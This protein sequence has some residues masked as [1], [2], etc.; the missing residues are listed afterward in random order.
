MKL[1]VKD[2]KFSYSSIPILE[3]ITMELTCSEILGIVGP[4]GAGKST[5]IRCIDNIL[6]P[7][8]GSIRLD[9]Q[10]I[11]KMSMMEIAKHI[12]Y[13][14]QSSSGVFPATVFDTVLIGRRPHIG[15]RSSEADE[16]KVWGILNMMG[17]ED[18]AMKDFNE[19]SGGQQQK[20]LI[21]RSLAQEADMLL[22]DEPTSNLDISHQFEVMDIIRNL[23]NQ[24]GISAIMAIH[25]LNLASRYTDRVLIMKA[26]KIFD[27]GVPSKVLTPEIIKSVYDVEVEVVNSSIGTPHIIP[28]GSVKTSATGVGMA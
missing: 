18:F 8:H 28:T 12:G 3:D 19:L 7:K 10:E 22:L 25:D 16:E 4:N 24:K 15:W 6:K 11:K 9:G 20:V 26:G 17:I 27:V 5:L 13:V 23:V 2:V 1:K 21:A 14:P